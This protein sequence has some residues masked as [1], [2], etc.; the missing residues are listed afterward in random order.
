MADDRKARTAGNPPGSPAYTVRGSAPGD[1]L[2]AYLESLG[3]K[4]VKGLAAANFEG[5]VGGR[6]VRVGCA[7]RSN[8][9]YL[10]IGNASIRTFQGWVLTVTVDT[11]LGTRLVLSAQKPS[12]WTRPIL[13]WRGLR[14]VAGLPGGRVAHATEPDWAHEILGRIAAEPIR[15]LFEDGANVDRSLGIGPFNTTLTMSATSIPDVG[16]RLADWIQACLD[17]VT[18][19]E[20]HPPKRVVN[21]TRMERLSEEDPKKAA[22]VMAIGLLFGIPAAL[23]ALVL[24]I[25]GALLIIGGQPCLR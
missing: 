20:S 12:A 6:R 17:L 25:G 14:P 8:H 16:E 19:T 5:Q 15:Q 2:E 1:Q 23:L 3:L 18:L 11:A 4:R 10:G 7:M 22:I 13:A 9:R 24:V 21:P